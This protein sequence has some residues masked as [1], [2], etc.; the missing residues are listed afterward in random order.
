M[1][2]NHEEIKRSAEIDRLISKVNLHRM[3]SEYIEAE[4]A[5]RRALLLD[6]S[7]A[8]VRELLGDMLYAR[9]QL[10]N[11]MQEYKRVMESGPGFASAETKYAKVVLEMGQNEYDRR[12]AQEMIENPKKLAEG[13]K[14]PLLAFILSALVPGMGQVYN[15]EIV[16]GAI[17]IGAFMLSLLVLALSPIETGNL[18]RALGV[19]LYPAGSE[20]PRNL[21]I[22]PLVVL[23]AAVLVFIY[24][25][26]VI[27]A[28][29]GAAKTTDH[30]RKSAEP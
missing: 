15:C 22:G 14:H 26:A 17:L 12:I 10:E 11:A 28:S 25:Y 2:V 4:D 27:D 18:L 19:F 3:R 1:S 30:K 8:D 29:I 5:C 16:K 20:T 21:P 7:R 9:G 6:E 23:F 13:P 24:I